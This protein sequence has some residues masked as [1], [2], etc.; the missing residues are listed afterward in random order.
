MHATLV[1]S[2][3]I[4]VLAVLMY[5]YGILIF[6]QAKYFFPS[7]FNAFGVG[8]CNAGPSIYSRISIFASQKNELAVRLAR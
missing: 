4:V 8:K 1:V 7:N 6:Y 5:I 2:L 3:S